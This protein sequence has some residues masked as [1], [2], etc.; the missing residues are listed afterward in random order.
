[1]KTNKMGDG[2]D[3]KHFNLLQAVDNNSNIIHT[4]D[5]NSPTVTTI[6]NTFMVY[7]GLCLL[8]PAGRDR[9]RAVNSKFPQIIDAS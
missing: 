6:G 5:S 8:F 7:S 9:A 4:S 3:E 1:M 2:E